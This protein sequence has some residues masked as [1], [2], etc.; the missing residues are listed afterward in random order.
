MY[1]LDSIMQLLRQNASK[2]NRRNH[3][4]QLTSNNMLN[5]RSKSSLSGVKCFILAFNHSTPRRKL[6]SS[7]S[8]S[9]RYFLFFFC[10]FSSL[11]FFTSL[12]LQCHSSTVVWYVVY[13]S[14]V[15]NWTL[16]ATENYVLQLQ[17]IKRRDSQAVKGTNVDCHFGEK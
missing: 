5:V 1:I 6:T 13:L 3:V 4:C 15:T 10:Q 11:C 7:S 2:K 14:A 17:R 12:P 16:Y 8:P 9:V